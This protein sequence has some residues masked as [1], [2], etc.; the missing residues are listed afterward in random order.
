MRAKIAHQGD[1]FMISLDP[2][3]GSEI[4]GKRPILIL[5]NNDLNQGGRALVAPI[6]QGS[7]F[8]RVAGWAVT[9]MDSETAM[10]GAIVVSQCRVLDLAASAG[11]KL[12]AVPDDLLN[13]CL[14]KPEAVI[15]RSWQFIGFHPC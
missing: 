5:S 11:K 7:S 4:R 12:E 2:T 9:L 13:D 3:I 15:A 6:T 14:A 1:I 8:E 10:Q